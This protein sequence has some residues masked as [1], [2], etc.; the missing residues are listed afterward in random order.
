MGKQKHSPAKIAR[1]TLER[2]TQ[3]RFGD[4]QP[5]VLLTNF[6]KYVEDFSRISGHAATSDATMPSCNW[7]EKK[8]SIIDFGVGSPPAALIMDL[9]AFVKP[10]AVIM[11]GMCGGLKNVHR[12]GDFFNPVAAIRDEGTSYHYM[13][14][15]VPALSSFV[16]QRF[17]VRE[18]EKRNLAYHTGV[19][20]T[21]N[22]RFWEFDEKFKKYIQEQRVQ[23]IEMECA[24][25]FTAGFARQVPTGAL[26][27]ISDL[28]LKPRGIKTK[29]LAGKVMKK[30]SPVHLQVGIETLIALRHSEKKEPHKLAF[31][32]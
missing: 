31:S 4:F 8:I 26:L 20:H 18:L 6:K 19:V 32:W 14:K 1:D 7:R 10:K 12:I 3:C 2:Y 23:G 22:I 11:L 16:I 28:P 17:I 24:T 9:L 29:A 21:T 27:L 30:F 15:R 13:P 5:Y 25:L